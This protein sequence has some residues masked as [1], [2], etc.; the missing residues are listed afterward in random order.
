MY[1]LMNKNKIIAEFDYIKNELGTSASQLVSG[2]LPLSYI[3]I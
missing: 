1:Y 2:S 3:V